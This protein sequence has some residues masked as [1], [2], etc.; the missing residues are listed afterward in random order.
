MSQHRPVVASDVPDADVIVAT[1]WETAEW[2]ADF[3]AAKGRKFHLM[4]DYEV[5]PYTPEDRVKAVYKLPFSRIAVS[6]WIADM[7]GDAKAAVVPNSVDQRL[8]NSPPRSKQPTFSMGV[9]Y[10]TTPRKN[11][12]LAL[13]AIALADIP[14]A[15][16]LCFSDHP[17]PE[18]MIVPRNFTCHVRPSAAEIAAIYASCDVWLFTSTS[19][20]FGLPILEAMACR[21]PVIAT[22]AGA[23]PDLIDGRNGVLVESDVDRIAEQIVR[24]S[25]MSDA[26]WRMASEAAYRTAT[27]YTWNDAVD[28]LEKALA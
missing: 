5:F 1:W 23:A 3:P 19:E 25:E 21:T 2:I 17:P 8:F 24:F 26:D 16:V 7:V 10:S 14:G 22:A 13:D 18:G 6:R 4:Q 12:R 9:L 15:R 27:S 28:R 11:S 20:G